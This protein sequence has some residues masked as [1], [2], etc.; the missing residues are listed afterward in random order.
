Y[1]FTI[2]LESA[3]SSHDLTRKAAVIGVVLE[4]MRV[5]LR[6]HQIVDGR[7]LQRIAMPLSNRF[8][9]LA[10]DPAEP[11]DADPNGHVLLLRIKCSAN[12]GMS[13]KGG[14]PGVASA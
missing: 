4:Q 10:A 14:S 6:V 12:L 5:R 9:Y 13:R 2:H 11:I 3:I 1:V 7:D 8:E